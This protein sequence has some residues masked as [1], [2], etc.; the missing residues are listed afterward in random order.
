MIKKSVLTSFVIFLLTH[1]C[2]ADITNIVLKPEEKKLIEQGEILVRELPTHNENGRTF[3]A[4]GLINAEV[5]H[6][7]KI[8]QDYESYPEFMPNL[9]KI[10]IL[11]Q[12]SKSAVLNYTLDLPL[13]KVKKYRL[14]TD[15]KHEN[16]RAVIAWKLIPWPGLKESEKIKDSTGYWNLSDYPDKKGYVLAVYHLYTDP[17]PI[18]TG[19]GWIVN[20]LTK[21]SVPDIVLNTRLRVQELY[22]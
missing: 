21:S 13:N 2:Y 5:D 7:Y 3:K 6:I 20:I 16:G 4:I 18:P 14:S 19:L 9:D 22:H 8:L 12:D 11:K 1:I 15:F 10:E 17:G